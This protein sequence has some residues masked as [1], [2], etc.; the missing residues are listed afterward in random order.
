MLASSLAFTI[1][2]PKIHQMKV[3]TAISLFITQR[4]QPAHC[5]SL[6]TSS[7][8][9]WVHWICDLGFGAFYLSWIKNLGPHQVAAALKST[10]L[11]VA[12]LSDKWW[13]QPLPRTHL[14]QMSSSMFSWHVLP[15]CHH[16]QIQRSLSVTWPSGEGWPVM[17]TFSKAL[18][19]PLS[20]N[21][22]FRIAPGC[23]IQLISLE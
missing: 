7:Y 16:I 1:T 12:W 11:N 14:N 21:W 5:A 15:R 2:S 20:T 6:K 23:H 10:T 8:E 3:S 22:M 4:S 18:P 13:Q 17:L 9:S 19:Q